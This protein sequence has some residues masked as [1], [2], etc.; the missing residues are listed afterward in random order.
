MSPAEKQRRRQHRKARKFRQELRRERKRWDGVLGSDAGQARLAARSSGAP[1]KLRVFSY[2]IS[3]DA[4][5]PGRYALDEGLLSAEERER[6]F[7]LVNDDPAAAV[8][9]LKALLERA[10]DAAILLNWLGRCYSLLGD[11]EQNEAVAARNLERN[12]DY[13][14]ARVHCAQLA[15]QRGELDQIPVIFDDK[16]DLKLLYPDRSQFH[17]TEYLAFA[18]VMAEY[19]M[20][21]G[22]HELAEA[23]LETMEQIDPDHEVSR[24][25]RELFD[26]ALLLRTVR[27]L[28]GFRGRKRLGR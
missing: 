16:F 1:M 9:E 15:L 12:P 8:E 14:F 23:T 22:E 25:L 24:R 21:T 2:D 19:Y 17:V 18:S 11:H 20:R 3:Y 7:C 6:L 28:L 13:L 26:T 4:L 27:K 5:P 10:P